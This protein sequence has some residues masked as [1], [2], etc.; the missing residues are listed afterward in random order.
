[1]V[2]VM[3]LA[4]VAAGMLWLSSGRHFLVSRANESESGQQLVSGAQSLVLACLEGTTY[5]TVSCGLP[6]A[7]VSCF[8]SSVAG[9]SVLVTSAGSPPNCR[10]SVTVNDR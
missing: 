5:G 4:V 10:L 6:G 2:L 8:P 7:A 9:R 3:I 1:M